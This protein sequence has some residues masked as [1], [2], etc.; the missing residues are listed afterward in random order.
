MKTYDRSVTRSL[1]WG[2]M[3]MAHV[4]MQLIVWAVAYGFCLVLFWFRAGSIPQ[5]RPVMMVFTSLLFLPP[6][7]FWLLRVWNIFRRADEY[8]FCPT[9]LNQPHHA[10]L[11]RD[12]FSF[13]GVIET[14]EG[15][16]AVETDAIFAGR[17]IVQPLME[18]YIGRTV[19]VGWNRETETVVVIG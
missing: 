5:V 16:F 13:M 1:L 14:G 11:R 19:T 2:S 7:G 17:G 3:E 10:P 4:R 9:E 8:V 15:R 12:M 6:V 18:D